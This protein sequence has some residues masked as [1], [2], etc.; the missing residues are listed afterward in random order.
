VSSGADISAN[1]GFDYDADVTETKR[2][3]IQDWARQNKTTRGEAKDP[4]KVE[5]NWI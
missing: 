2:R 1:E 3:K 4:G 5:W